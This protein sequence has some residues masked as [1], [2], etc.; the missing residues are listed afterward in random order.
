MRKGIFPNMIL[1]IS[2]VF[3]CIVILFSVGFAGEPKYGGTLVIGTRIPQYNRLDVRQ[4]SSVSQVPTSDL[5]YNRLFSWGKGTY[6]TLVP[7]LA[8]RYETQ[9]SKVWIIH[10]RQGVKFH[11]GREMTAEDVKTNFDWRIET[12][13]GWKPLRNK[14]QIRYLN[15]VEVIDKYTVKIVLDKPF[16][17]LIRVLAY[18]IRGIVPPEEVEKWQDEFTLHPCGTGP[19]KVVD[20]KPPDRV[21][22]ERF[23]DYWGPRPYIDRVEVM[24]V[25]S[26][27]ARLIALEKGDIDICQL[28][29]EAK[30]TLKKN[31][32]LLF[33]KSSMESK[34]EY[35][36]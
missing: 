10:L 4:L 13:K 5:I 12:P 6:D 24:F 7:A 34:L 35:I 30:P 28:S 23:D 15:R 18:A 11:N 1:L 25:R 32:N 29:D 33:F 22:L 36:L 3:L 26:N 8:I 20:V 9:D 19:F 21:V 31:P 2:S 17:P 14:D 16:S 27:E